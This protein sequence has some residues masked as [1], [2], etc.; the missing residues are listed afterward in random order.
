MV[1]SFHTI[2]IEC[3]GSLKIDSVYKQGKNYRPQT[4]VE[5]CRYADAEKQQWSMFTDDDDG[6]GFFEA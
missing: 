3:N 2:C 1:V 4:Y 5:E 6:D